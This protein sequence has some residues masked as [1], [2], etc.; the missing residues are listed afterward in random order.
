M[1]IHSAEFLIGA[2]SPGQFPPPLLPE[3]AFVGKSNVGKSSLINTLLNRK[4]LVKTSGT[5]GKTREI[6][7]FLIN[8]RFRFVDLPGYGFSRAAKTKQ[9]S[10]EGLIETYLSE[11]PCLKGLV[12]IFDVR[13][14]PGPL[15]RAMQGWLEGAGLRYRLIANKADKLK[16]S[17]LG[18][19]LSQLEQGLALPE[20][21]LAFSAKSRQGCDILWKC[22]DGWLA[23]PLN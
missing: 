20:P 22:L 23:E 2:A 3:V 8:E 16:K 15:D 18:S 5:P 11:R 6:N 19:Q 4:R 1:K 14:S 10:W 21:P 12:L 17:R 13:H 7:F 9:R